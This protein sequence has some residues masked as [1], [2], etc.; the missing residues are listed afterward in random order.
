M[1]SGLS[2]FIA[3]RR[4][5]ISD[6][7]QLARTSALVNV[8]G[9]VVHGLQRERGISNVFLGSRGK[10]F[11]ARLDEQVKA[12]SQLEMAMR[13]SFDALD[14]EAGH[15]G[16]GARLFSRIAFV[17]HELDALPGLRR[18]VATLELPPAMATA[19]YVKLIAGLLAVVFEAA[20]AA[21]N[22]EISRLLVAMFNFMQGKEFS[23]QERAFGSAAF[24]S[25]RIDAAQQQQW[26]HLIQQQERCEQVFSDFATPTLLEGWKNCQDP[27]T[28]A[29]VERL[30]RIGCTLAAGILDPNLSQ[31][32]FGCCSR[33]IDAMKTVED[34]MADALL[35]LCNSKIRR[36][37]AEL[38]DHQMIL[39]AVSSQDGGNP[40][41][42]LSEQSTAQSPTP[43]ATP[44]GPHLERS[45]LELVHEQT[46][47]LQAMS[48]ELDTVRASLNERKM[49]ERAKGLLMAHRNLSEDEAYKMLRQ[50]AMNQNRRI[51]DVAEAVLAMSDYLA[52][53]K[54]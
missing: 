51:N 47:R 4:C 23:G 11:A 52:A 15:L 54:P 5:E 32:W 14:T 28:M 2:F 25:G 8:V 7:E 9:G 30:R 1:K 45:I 3:A 39:E 21:T 34:Q 31:A 6:L 40:P 48:D 26:L 16:N 20:D 33:R 13:A 12:C 37:R 36:A 17:L 19:A 22:P 44:Y 18:R 43:T 10:R 27:A 50:T 53:G 29:E 24:V 49:V 46:N 41:P 42:A 35:A 38:H